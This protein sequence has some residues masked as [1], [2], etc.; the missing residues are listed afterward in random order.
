MRTFQ[1]LIIFGADL[2][3][4][5]LSLWLSYVLTGADVWGADRTDSI[6]LIIFS[7]LTWLFLVVVANPYNVSRNWGLVKIMKSQFSFIVIH[8]LVVASLILLLGKQYRP[9]QLMLMYM[10]FILSFF[11][12]KVFMWYGSSLWMER[13][14]DSRRYIIVGDKALGREVRRHFLVHHELGNRFYGFFSGDTEETSIQQL[15]L[16][17]E[18]NKIEE[19]FYCLPKATHSGLRRMV[20]FGMNE[21][22]KVRLVSDHRSF[23]QRTIALSQY[24]QVPVFDVS[25]IPLDSIRNLRLKRAFDI[26][27]SLGVTI[28]VLSWMIPLIGIIIKL[29]SPGPFFFR[30]RRSG[31]DNKPFHCLKFRTMVV[32]SE[33]DRQ[34]TLDD[35]RV[36]RVGAFLRKTS[37][38]EFP[39]FLNVLSGE[40]S[41]VGPRPHPIRLNEKFRPLINKY[42]IRHYVKPGVTGLAQVLGYRGETRLIREMRNR[43]TLDRFYIENWSFYFDIKIILMTVLSVVRGSEKA[44]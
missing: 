41:V 24:D 18:A 38:D 26:F 13:K 35:P 12:W 43:I 31:K 10:L 21:L 9:I 23:D 19:I 37:L 44:Y 4:L 34:A 3:L 20:D 39:Q 15:K 33:G 42:M 40:M 2:I 7:N 11:L 30:Q 14:G 25:T 1:R 5:N 28:V 32:N 6:Y 8:V 29:E 16:F 17:C 36:T 27:F 22:I